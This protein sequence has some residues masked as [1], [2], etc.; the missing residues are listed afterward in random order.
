[1]WSDEFRRQAGSPPD[2]AWGFELGDGTDYGIP[3]WGNRELQWYTDSTA[4]AA[5][6]G[7]SSL[8]ITARTTAEGGGYTSA[9][10]VTKGKVELRYGR[11]ETR[12]RVPRGAGLWSAIW[13]LGTNIDCTPWPGCGEIDI[14]EQVGREPY[15][16][17]GTI[18]GPGYAGRDGCS[19]TIQLE[20]ELASDF[21][22]FAAE[23]SERQIEWSLDGR[24]YHVATPDDVPGAWVFDHPFYLLINLAVGGDLGGPVAEETTFPQQLLVDYVRVYAPSNRTN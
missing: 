9:R 3:G 2:A 10:I 15:G 4:N 23:W 16:A 5:H 12:V 11:I 1:V 19:G 13:A 24:A 18:H 8:A 6:D 14:M 20:E 7:R 21:H 17:F 22:L